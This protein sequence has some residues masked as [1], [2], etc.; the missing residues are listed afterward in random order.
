M[1]LRLAI[2][3]GAIALLIS[4]ASAQPTTSK[5]SE[6]KK[7]ATAAMIS[8]PASGEIVM[9]DRFKIDTST[10][11]KERQFPSAYKFGNNIFVSYSE[12]PDAIIASPVDAMIISRDN[13]KTWTEKIH[14]SDFYLTSMVEK[15]G[16]LYGVA[17]FT[18]PDSPQEERMIYW[19]SAD[20]GKTWS[21]HDGVVKAPAGKQ[22]R[23][24]QSVWGS[25]LFHRGMQ[26]MDDGSLQG[27]MYG[28]FD[29]DSIYTT[30][31]V[32][33]TD[34]C[35]T[36]SVVSVIASGVPEGD[37]KKPDGYCEPTVA[38][39]RDGSLLCVMRIGSYLPL[40]QSR[41]LDNGATWSKPVPLPGLTS[42]ESESVDPELQ[43]MSSGVLALSYGRPNDEIAFSTDG[44]GYNWDHHATTYIGDT[45]GY[46]GLVETAPGRLLVVADQGRLGA[47][48][49]A[50]WARFIDVHLKPAIATET[51][52][53]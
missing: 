9:E 38:K 1:K 15:G 7:G 51:H 24:M 19:T 53:P 43:V 11:G 48:E 33:S 12:H 4:S 28:F 5:K 34:N 18:Y 52:R 31:W 10:D 27:P 45:T 42:T 17:Y 49:V 3:C 41:S 22:F 20:M 8:D 35:A 29:G 50:I 13:G 36:W 2:I 40:C 6:V 30:A 37:Y 16:I 26:V 46:T 14:H 44:S 23:T 47:K 32:K 21:R 39:T 25:M